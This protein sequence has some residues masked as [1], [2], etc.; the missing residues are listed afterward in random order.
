VAAD[1]LGNAFV[2]GYFQGNNVDFD[3][4][5]GTD[6]RNSN[7]DADAFWSKFDST[8]NYVM[9]RTLGGQDWD[10][11]RGI[12]VTDL[13]RIFAAGCFRNTDI[14]FAPVDAPCLDNSD[15]H[16]ASGDYDCFLSKYMPEGCW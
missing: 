10:Q 14:E 4:G 11:V 5:S 7:G 15:I 3:P 9:A 8:G 6:L 1:E 12:Y 2:G 16:S 13:G